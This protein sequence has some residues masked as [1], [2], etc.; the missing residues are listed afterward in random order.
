MYQ[1]YNTVVTSMLHN[2]VC[3]DINNLLISCYTFQV[4]L[5]VSQYTNIQHTTCI[6]NILFFFDI[7]ADTQLCCW[8]YQSIPKEYVKIPGTS[9]KTEYDTTRIK[10]FSKASWNK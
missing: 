8:I 6:G 9:G 10:Y 5:D 4:F 7:L 3:G 2:S 1:L